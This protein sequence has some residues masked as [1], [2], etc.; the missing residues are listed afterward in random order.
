MDSGRDLFLFIVVIIG[1][2]VVWSA[3]GGPER[4]SSRNPF[5]VPLPPLNTGLTYN[6]PKAY[7]PGNY[8]FDF[9]PTSGSSGSGS[10]SHS[11]ED[12]Q[13][14]P[15]TITILSTTFTGSQYA[16]IVRF[17]SSTRGAKKDLARE[18]FL[19]IEISS[20]AKE[21][22]DITGFQ[23]VSAFSK[24]AYRIPEAAR[25]PRSGINNVTGPAVL[26]PG[27]NAIISTGRSPIGTSFRT[28]SCTGY[29]EQFQDFEPRL[30]TSCPAPERELDSFFSNPDIDDVCEDYVRSVGN[31]EMP[32]T[33]IPLGVKSGC[34]DF[35]NERLSY[36]G[37]VAAHDSDSKFLKDEWRIFLNR[38][39]EIWRN[40]RE[41]IHLL[42]RQGD[43]I[44]T[45]SY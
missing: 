14:E 31:C 35:I 1:L 28:N 7:Q 4:E 3:T 19:K 38:D 25:I 34:R 18:E 37:C 12:E 21:P 40:N 8:S 30:R 27:D 36:N 10:S 29:F 22:I 5:I 26:L 33:G 44:D 13:D 45:I 16:D 15:E 39:Q 17:N 6:F 9:I 23:L 11:N 32:L 2:G 41:I 42:D 24:R 43:L 20:R